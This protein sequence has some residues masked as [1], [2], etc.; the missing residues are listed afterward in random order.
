MSA[1]VLL[2]N[3]KENPFFSILDDFL[4]RQLF[5]SG[6]ITVALNMKYDSDIDFAHMYNGTDNRWVFHRYKYRITPDSFDEINKHKNLFFLTLVAQSVEGVETFLKKS[7]DQV[8]RLTLGR[9]GEQLRDKF[10]TNK[11]R[12]QFLSEY[13]ED[14]KK[15]FDEVDRYKESYR[16]FFLIEQIRHATVHS[17]Q[18]ITERNKSIDINLPL[19]K[20]WFDVDTSSGRSAI[21]IKIAST[22]QIL[23]V[24]S[25]LAFM[26]FEC[27]STQHKFPILRLPAE[28]TDR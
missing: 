5:L 6:S 12:L 17:G 13:C 26:I 2:N 21:W 15:Y 18:I 16:A 25:G 23:I 3:S 9:S 24:L 14:I 20:Q 4:D 10:R 22:E 27:L 8:F 28:S 1:Q 11:E 7:I 19:F